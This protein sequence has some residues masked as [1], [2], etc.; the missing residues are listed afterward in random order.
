M[1]L[2][3]RRVCESLSAGSPRLTPSQ[4]SNAPC[5]G[6]LPISSLLLS[7]KT[8]GLLLLHLGGPHLGLDGARDLGWAC[9]GRAYLTPCL[10]T[11]GFH[12]LMQ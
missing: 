11:L 10:A 2:P 6:H 9:L 8:P 4:G 3:L 12:F 1:R 7:P 5:P